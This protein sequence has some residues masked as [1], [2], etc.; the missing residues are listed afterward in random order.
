MQS[1]LVVAA[2]AVVAAKGFYDRIVRHNEALTNFEW[3]ANFT[4]TGPFSVLAIRLIYATG[5]GG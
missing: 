2:M 5:G 4:S 1:R 3:S